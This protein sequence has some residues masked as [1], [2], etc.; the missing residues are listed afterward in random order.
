MPHREIVVNGRKTP[1]SL[2]DLCINTAI[3][4]LRY[5][6]DVGE[7]DL[8]LLD[9]ILPHC[10]L[11]QLMHVEKSSQGRDLSQVTD[12]LWKKF[13]EKQFGKEKTE[14]VVRRMVKSKMT[15]KWIQ[16]YEAKLEYIAEQEKEAAARFKQRYEKID[17]RKQSRQV[18]ICT[19]V[20]PSKNKRGFF[21]GSGPGYNV[22]NVKSNLMKKSKVDYLNS[23]EMKNRAAMKRMASQAQRNDGCSSSM[24]RP[25]Q[26]K[27][28]DSAS[29]SKPLKPV[30]RRF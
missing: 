28:K 3:D 13:Y 20:P 25:V 2:V 4:N 9:R 16:L 15:F 22:S 19:K 26:F 24:M 21:G 18:Q 7:T 1:P 29:T 6:G 14:E 27:G 17:A 5:L 8:Y 11:D 23:N 10:T 12:N 30:G